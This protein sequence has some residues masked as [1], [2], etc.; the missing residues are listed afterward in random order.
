MAKREFH[1]LSGPWSGFSIQDGRRI[2]EALTLTIEDN[3]ISGS[4]SDADGLFEVEGDYSPQT[5]R[6]TLTR[7]YTFT[8]EP[9]QEGVGLPYQYQGQ[10]NGDF[11]AGIWFCRPYPP[12]NGEFE[13]WPADEDSLSALRLEEHELS[14]QGR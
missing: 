11:V 12:V 9:S 13:M 4:G 14:L 10:W 8:T 6:V 2:E 5:Q 3:R 1:Q 7:R